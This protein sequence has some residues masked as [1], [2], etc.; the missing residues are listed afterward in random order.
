[1]KDNNNRYAWTWKVKPEYLDE[2]VR[3]HL[4]PWQEILEEHKKAGISNYSIFQNG[5]QFFYIYECA[6]P[7]AATKYMSTSEA[8]K[9]WDAIT[10]LMVEGS[11]DYGKDNPIEFMK[12][13]FY[14]K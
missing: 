14:L 5:N 6:D 4:D 7:A 3:M 10:S 9:K 11:F 8:C 12:E 1:M 13:I 2:Y